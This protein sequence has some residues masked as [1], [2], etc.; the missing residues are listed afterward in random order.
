MQILKHK[1]LLLGLSI[2]VIGAM[3]I[4][5]PVYAA[6]N[7]CHP[8]NNTPKSTRGNPLTPAQ[9]QS[10]E[11]C[12]DANNAPSCLKKDSIIIDLNTIVNFLSAG[13]GLIVVGVIILGGIQY[14]MAGDKAD[15]VTKARQRM[16]NGIIALLAFI[17]TYAFLQWI[18]PG[19]IFG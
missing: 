19:G 9:L 4:T 18:I 2:L 16:L 6:N 3:L 14:S 11:A 15:A 1:I 5:P 8:E 17:F 12:Q 10:C 13:V 7:P